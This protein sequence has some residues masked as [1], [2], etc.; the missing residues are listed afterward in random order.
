MLENGLVI[1]GKYKIIKEIGRGGMGT[2]YLAEH[3]LL[4]QK[5]AIKE[6]QKEKEGQG[7]MLRQ[8]LIAET[9]I[10]KHLNHPNLPRI[11]DVIQK[12]DN[13]LLVMDYIEGV[14]LQEL[15]DM[16]GPQPERK[17]IKW[18]CEICEVLLYLHTRRP[19]IIYCDLKPSNIMMQSDGRIKLIDFGTAREY[20]RK[21]TADDQC[22]GSSGYA[23]P[24][25]YSGIKQ[26]DERTDIFSFG[27]TLYSLLMGTSSERSLSDKDFPNWEGKRV[28]DRLKQIIMKCT[29]QQPE[30]R[31]Q[32]CFALKFALNHLKKEELELQTRRK[33]KRI[34]LEIILTGFIICGC[35]SIVIRQSVNKS[36]YEQAISFINQAEKAVVYE[37]VMDYYK[38]ALQIMPGEKK[39]YE[40]IAEHFINYNDFSIEDAAAMMSLMEASYAGK[41][42]LDIFSREDPKGYC[43]FCYEVGIGY[44]YYMGGMIGKK[45]AR[46]WFQDIRRTQSPD[47]SASKRKRA[48]LYEQICK[49]YDTFV[50]KGGD[51]SGENVKEGFEEFYDTLHELNQITLKKT[52][53]ESDAASVYL[54]SKEIAIEI[55][56]YAQEF[57]GSNRISAKK[58]MEE[59]FLIEGE[60][61]EQQ[62]RIAILRIFF[63]DSEIEELR[64]FVKEA[65][66]KVLLADQTLSLREEE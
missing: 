52:S 37:K 3:Q 48:G 57:L 51:K 15:I 34:G 28:S 10:L 53:T 43:E 50:E 64:L 30:K 4:E 41:N 61:K 62:D 58:L 17:V 44:F 26:N 42:V 8:R 11:I 18:A 45:E 22:L 13:V 59:L 2:V 47:F 65:K 23:A 38:M 36:K 9:N 25:Q 35:I 55:G 46:V 39:I 14:T 29:E 66:R 32:D 54:I 31:Y 27:M 21:E 40:S 16:W 24:E 19:P 12:K 49:Y 63:E 5:W 33:Q 56:N 60:T 6:I 20:C 1:D 7:G